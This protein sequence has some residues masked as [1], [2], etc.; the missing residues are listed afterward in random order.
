MSTIAWENDYLE[1]AFIPLFYDIVI[2][3]VID[4][5]PD[6][7]ENW[8]NVIFDIA[9]GFGSD[10][11]ERGGLSGVAKAIK[12]APKT[13]KNSISDL[14]VFAVIKNQ[15]E[16]RKKFK[17]ILAKELDYVDKRKKL[18]I[19]ID[20]LDRCKPLFALQTLE[21]V[22]HLFDIP[23]V[24]FLL[25]MDFSQ[26]RHSVATVYGQDMDSEGYLRRFANHLVKLPAPSIREYVNFL[27]KEQPISIAE[28]Y[29]KEF[30]AEMAEMIESY[31]HLSIRDVNA[32]YDSFRMFFAHKY[33]ERALHQYYMSSLQYLALIILKYKN[34]D[35]YKQLLE[36][37]LGK[38]I[39][40]QRDVGPPNLSDDYNQRHKFYPKIKGHSNGVLFDSYPIKQ[41]WTVKA[42]MEYTATNAYTLENSQIFPAN[43]GQKVAIPESQMFHPVRQQRGFNVSEITLF[44][45]DI[46]LCL[47][48][49]QEDLRPVEYMAGQVEMFICN[50]NSI[51]QDQV[52]SGESYIG[53]T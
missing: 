18:L 1:N 43:N 19:I 11:I 37:T 21:I 20:E 2:S 50:N 22:K 15:R 49:K 23:N 52:Y 42:E 4:S 8:G 7:A 29:K 35:M 25:A 34:V 33:K 36:G 13:L 3:D 28:Q 40:R 5:S 9:K 27:F 31:P 16:Q 46:R 45:E 48:L 30:L 10:L 39:S 12:K 14:E 53:E 24:V 26:L 41:K 32:I 51:N 17:E 47:S 38:S 6:Y 44:M